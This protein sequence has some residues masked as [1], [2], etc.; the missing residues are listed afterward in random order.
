MCVSDRVLTF[1]RAARLR[2]RSSKCRNPA[3]HLITARSDLRDGW[4]QT[5]RWRSDQLE[6][7]NR[8]Y[9]RHGVRT[10]GP[11]C[12]TAIFR[13]C[14]GRPNAGLIATAT[15]RDL[16]YILG[17][18]YTHGS[19]ETGTPKRCPMVKQPRSAATRPPPRA[20]HMPRYLTS[21]HHAGYR[22]NE[23]RLRLVE[24]SFRC[25]ANRSLSRDR[26]WFILHHLP[27]HQHFPFSR[28]HHP[29]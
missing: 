14:V 25:L 26:P 21:K 2:R 5:T 24:S 6:R 15:W 17:R 8:K 16:N 28:T 9:H 29:V 23:R 4:N 13:R 19:Y 27:I 11:P 7:S 1:A 18:S 10:G 22:F 20:A 3:F 12:W